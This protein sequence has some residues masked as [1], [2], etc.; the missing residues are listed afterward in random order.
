MDGGRWNALGAAVTSSGTQTSSGSDHRACAGVAA[1]RDQVATPS[2]GNAI[3]RFAIS[4]RGLRQPLKPYSGA[5]VSEQDI[6]SV[7]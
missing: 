1:R 4:D 5:L 3:R 7:L 6:P 2:P